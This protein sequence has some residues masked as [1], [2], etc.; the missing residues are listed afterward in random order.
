LK[1]QK[2][3]QNHQQP[4]TKQQ[5]SFLTEQPVQIIKYIN[6]SWQLD[7][8]SFENMKDKPA[9]ILCISGMFR[10]GKSTL[11][12][13]IIGVKTGG[14]QISSQVQGKTKGFWMW[15]KEESDHYL[16]FLDSEGLS[17]TENESE[18]NLQIL[19][20]A[21]LFSSYLIVNTTKTL[22]TSLLEE[23]FAASQLLEGFGSSNNPMLLFLIRDCYLQFDG[24]DGPRD[25][26]MKILSRQTESSNEIVKIKNLE[27][28][29][30]LSKFK[31]FLDCETL[32]SPVEDYSDLKNIENNPNLI[33]EKFKMQLS[34]LVDKIK[35]SIPIK[36]IQLEDSLVQVNGSN[37]ALILKS[38]IKSVNSVGDELS[39]VLNTNLEK[40]FDEQEM[41]KRVEMFMESL[42]NE[43]RTHEVSFRVP[44]QLKNLEFYSSFKTQFEGIFSFENYF[45]MEEVLGRSIEF[46][47]TSK[48]EEYKFKL[49]EIY[50]QKINF[51]DGIEINFATEIK[52]IQDLLD[53]ISN[54]L[55]QSIEN[56]VF[57]I[58]NSHSNMKKT[59]FKFHRDVGNSK[60][61][62]IEK[63]SNSK[64]QDS[65]CSTI[66][67][68]IL[69][70]KNS[71]KKSKFSIWNFKE[72]FL[73]VQL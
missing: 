54:S 1:F 35:N 70:F 56:I 50:H 14:F 25:Y 20:L 24:N 58:P 40:N 60:M 49:K 62:E 73:N 38:F 51:I 19:T 71:M 41:K 34:V 26:L 2:V 29:Q 18:L 42:Q 27:R 5:M 46:K 22:D 16:V 53:G 15:I 4:I 37:F 3:L 65:M 67:K 33:R 64:F 72:S 36:T 7:E 23:C 12:N 39:A 9:K 47:K 28:S 8:S 66:M 63:I 11:L 21:M 61:S 30:F 52:R 48:I 32:I 17:D 45:P 57:S 43:R 68:E 69:N 31:D 55:H 44:D 59:D 13:Q 6:N 10:K